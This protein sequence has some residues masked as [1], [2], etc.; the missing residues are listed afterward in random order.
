MSRQHDYTLPEALNMGYA[1]F[2]LIFPFYA[3]FHFF[4]MSSYGAINHQGV[5]MTNAFVLLSI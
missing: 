5:N 1:F 2:F 4:L 3:W